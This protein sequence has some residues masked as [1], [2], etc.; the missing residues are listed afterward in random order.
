LLRAVSFRSR[1]PTE[2]GYPS[3]RHRIGIGTDGLSQEIEKI[4]QAGV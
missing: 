1:Q 2:W 4:L 3:F